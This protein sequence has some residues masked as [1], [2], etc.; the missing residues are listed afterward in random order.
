MGRRRV[1]VLDC[2]CLSVTLDLDDCGPRLFIDPVLGFEDITVSGR[3]GDSDREPVVLPSRFEE[4]GR[5]GLKVESEPRQV[6]FLVDFRKRLF[7]I[8][9]DQQERMGWQVGRGPT[10]HRPPHDATRFEFVDRPRSQLH[11]SQRQIVGVAVDVI[12]RKHGI[13]NHATEGG[14]DE[15]DVPQ[16]ELGS[17]CSGWSCL[18]NQGVDR[19]IGR[20]RV[21]GEPDESQ[22][23][24]AIEPGEIASDEDRS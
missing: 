9:L 20:D 18:G 4:C 8:N 2:Q 12:R 21:R 13:H 19:Q 16:N 22:A 10:L 7:D 17:D 3:G 6:V 1:R 24:A 11:S 23:G 14:V 15:A 5:S